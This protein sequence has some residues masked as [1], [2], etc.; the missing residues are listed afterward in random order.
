MHPSARRA[1]TITGAAGGLLFLW[2]LLTM[3]PGAPLRP[4]PRDPGYP[5]PLSRKGLPPPATAALTDS[6]DAPPATDKPHI[7]IEEW[8]KSRGR[9]AR[10]LVAAW[11]ITGRQSYLDE[12]ARDIPHDPTVCLAVIATLTDKHS[13]PDFELLIRPWIERLMAAAPRNAEGLQL[14][15]QLSAL[16][17]DWPAAYAALRDAM[18]S[19][20]RRDNH[21][22]DRIETIREALAATGASNADPWTLLLRSPFNAAG[23]TRALSLHRFTVPQEINAAIAA[24]D[25]LRAQAAARIGLAAAEQYADTWGRTLRDELEANHLAQDILRAF[26]GHTFMGQEGTTSAFILQKMEDDRRVLQLLYDQRSDT[27]GLY[28][29]A[30]LAVQ[31]EYARRFIEGSERQAAEWLRSKPSNTPPP[32]PTPLD[33]SRSQDIIHP[34]RPPP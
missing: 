22:G 13:R 15:S 16:R 1:F 5:L 17:Q 21:M 4:A 14:K 20:G 6:T 24:G 8:L 10:G 7:R 25:T 9:D 3:Q 23:D 11:E 29:R 33:P 32:V 26:P 30:P 27:A 19:G 12:A 31:T 34:V 28:N 2:Y 18:L